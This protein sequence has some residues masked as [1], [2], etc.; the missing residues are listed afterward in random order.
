MDIDEKKKV[1]RL[2]ISLVVLVLLG[3]VNG[4]SIITAAVGALM[5]GIWFT[6]IFKARWKRC[7]VWVLTLLLGFMLMN[8]TSMELARW[9]GEND[10]RKV[11]GNFFFC[12]IEGISNFKALVSKGL[13]EL[14]KNG[15]PDFMVVSNINP[16]FLALALFGTVGLL[17]WFLKG[18]KKQPNVE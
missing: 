2:A 6:P 16:G 7:A 1:V 10:F 17:C 15:N 13:P 11:A 14:F 5:I 8:Y 9:L 3:M 18:I 4:W 12:A